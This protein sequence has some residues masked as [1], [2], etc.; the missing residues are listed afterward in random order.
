MPHAPTQRPSYGER[1]RQ[2]GGD[3]MPDSVCRL[4]VQ[5]GPDTVDLS[6]PSQTPVGLLLPSI[7]DLV[8][9]GR[10]ASEEGRQWYLSR[11]GDARLD[12]AVSLHDNAIHD[13]ELLLLT[14]TPTPTP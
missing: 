13:G 5:H 14:T 6:L 3:A 8:H 11:V 1:G 2:K 7:V 10:V 12:E 4:S 9:G